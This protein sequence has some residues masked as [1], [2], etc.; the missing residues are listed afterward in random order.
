ME[1]EGQKKS[2]LKTASVPSLDLA[3]VNNSLKANNLAKQEVAESLR[4]ND[5]M[6]LDNLDLKN[7][8]K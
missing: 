8:L 7:Q 4:L 6:L 3:S 5:K 2:K 1:T